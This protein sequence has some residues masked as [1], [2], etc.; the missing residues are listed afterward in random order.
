[1]V[2]AIG[3]HGKA[4]VITD[5]WLKRRPVAGA[6]TGACAGPQDDEGPLRSCVR[7]RGFCQDAVA[8]ITS[9][10]YHPGL[11][12]EPGAPTDVRGGETGSC[13]RGWKT[14]HLVGS[15]GERARH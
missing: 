10:R 1:M 8:A 7:G 9:S 2:N 5:S 3:V 6:N 4:N 12:F 11:T 15:T 14:R 13:G